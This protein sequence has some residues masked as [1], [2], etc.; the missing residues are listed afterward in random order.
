MGMKES[1]GRGCLQCDYEDTPSSGT[2]LRPDSSAAAKTWWAPPEADGAQDGDAPN[3]GG[4]GSS[5]AA[6]RSG[7]HGMQR[8]PKL[9]WVPN[10]AAAARALHL[11]WPLRSDPILPSSEYLLLVSLLHIC[12]A[13]ALH[14]TDQRPVPDSSLTVSKPSYR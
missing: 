1:R 5:A 3:G 14:V 10:P 2:R 8:E 11:L 7:P 4:Y 6:A 13:T 9:A 12:W